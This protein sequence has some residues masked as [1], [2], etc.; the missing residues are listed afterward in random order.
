MGKVNRNIAD[1][2]TGTKQEKSIQK[3]G[4]EDAYQRLHLFTVRMFHCGYGQGM[5]ERGTWVSSYG[6]GET[7]LNGIQTMARAFHNDQRP[8]PVIYHHVKSP[9]D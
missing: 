8:S 3:D 7:K 9:H 2:E 4:L 5:T 1:L 6:E